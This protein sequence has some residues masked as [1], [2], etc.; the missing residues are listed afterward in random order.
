[1]SE[2]HVEPQD[3]HNKLPQHI[4]KGHQLL[5]SRQDLSARE[6]DVLAL[7]M[8]A[9]K[10]EHWV[11]E[12][13]KYHF[14]CA[15]ISNY[16]NINN[17]HVAS[18]LAPIAERLSERKVGIKDLEKEEFEYTPLF[19]KISYKEGV[20]TVSPNDELKSEYMEYK[21][22]FAL[23]NTKNFLSL[24]REYSKRLYEILCRFKEK[25]TLKTFRITELKGLFGILDEK[26]RLK[27]DKASFKNN[28]VFMQR[29]VRESIA[30]IMANA[31]TKKELLFLPSKDESVGYE[32]E[33]KSNKI[34]SIKFLYR[35][36]DSPN[37]SSKLNELAAIDIIKE[38]E[39]KRLSNKDVKLSSSEL[40]TLAAAYNMINK[41]ELADAVMAGIQSRKKEEEEEKD[42]SFA[43][44]L[45]EIDNLMDK[46]QIMAQQSGIVEY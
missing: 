14:T 1:M 38:L 31:Q 44:D 17:K 4:K 33:K 18:T 24:K 28:S 19:K 3:Q 27:K 9:M 46:F 16:L 23:I 7:V 11:N 13:P 21:Q 2:H 10:V 20:L 26:D 40:E 12:T 36:I 37:A 43:A 45:A 42:N 25:G 39:L 29:C 35:W 34:I 32:T 5:F 30:E 6:Q 22:G 15:D 41:P 8:S